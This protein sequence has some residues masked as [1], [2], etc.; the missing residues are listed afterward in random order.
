MGLMFW[1]VCLIRVMRVLLVELSIC[2][3]RVVEYW[4]GWVLRQWRLWIGNDLGPNANDVA[5]PDMK[6]RMLMVLAALHPLFIHL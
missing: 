1:Q 3:R 5:S 6:G 4:R 2:V